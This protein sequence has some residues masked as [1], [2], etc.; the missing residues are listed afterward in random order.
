[1]QVL[2]VGSH[3]FLHIFF[4]LKKVAVAIKNSVFKNTSFYRSD[5]T[6]LNT[7]LLL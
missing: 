7:F 4:T 6:V 5:T 3:W 1:M 2:G